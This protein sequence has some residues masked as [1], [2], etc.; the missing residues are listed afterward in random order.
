MITVVTAVVS[1]DVVVLAARVVFHTH[2]ST[3]VLRGA[4]AG[5]EM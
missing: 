5:L 1:R 2:S 4:N 3:D